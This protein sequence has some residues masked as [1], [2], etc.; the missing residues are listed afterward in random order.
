MGLVGSETAKVW[1]LVDGWSDRKLYQG[2]N[3]KEL[4]TYDDA[5]LWW[6]MGYWFVN[7]VR[8]LP[9]NIGD[10]Y[11]AVKRGKDLKRFDDE[12][13]WRV[14]RTKMHSRLMDARLFARRVLTRN[15]RRGPQKPSKDGKRV[16]VLAKSTSMRPMKDKKT[17]KTKIGNVYLDTVMQRLEERGFEL[18]KVER[19]FGINKDWKRLTGA[20]G[21]TA[22]ESYQPD[23]IDNLASDGTKG[24][25]ELWGKVRP[26]VQGTFIFGGHDLS[27]Y[28]SS[29][30]DVLFETR[31]PQIITLIETMKNML[32]IENPDAVLFISDTRD[33]ERAIIV[34]AKQKGVPTFGLIHGAFSDE[35]WFYK[36]KKG[37]IAQDLS[38]KAPFS[39]TPDY[40]L[41]YGP[42]DKEWLRRNNYP[43]KAIAVTGQPMYDVLANADKLYDRKRTCEKLGIDSKKKIILLATGTHALPKE[44][45]VLTLRESYKAAKELSSEV[46]LVLKLHPNEGLMDLYEKTSEETGVHP[47]I[48]KKHD[49]FELLYACDVLMQNHSNA[50]IEAMILGK[51][52]ISL[53]F[54]EEDILGAVKEGA[55]LQVTK[56]GQLTAAIKKTLFDEKTRQGLKAGAERFLYKRLFKTDGKAS[57]RICDFIEKV[58]A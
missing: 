23:G 16:L 53:N 40:L 50:A 39:P 8:Y 21:W 19:T 5:S 52:V 1:E 6:F 9:Y 13:K 18:V 24:V 3:I 2:K 25:N 4:F 38:Y 26:K 45:S 42:A 47:K 7:K 28:I 49:F 10:L 22:L 43:P 48:L 34:A 31:V 29:S 58:T 35:L 37:E 36:H 57:D 11:L 46:E 41:V 51:P 15:R 12:A 32:D 20:R 17:G 27:K 30:L 56:P 44:E 14:F 55:S 33:T 54:V